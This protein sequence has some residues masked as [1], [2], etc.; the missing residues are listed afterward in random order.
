MSSKFPIFVRFL[1]SAV[2]L[3]VWRFALILCYGAYNS[4]K[5]ELV[6]QKLRWPVD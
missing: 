3:R 1:M 5:R 2:H 4:S 6:D